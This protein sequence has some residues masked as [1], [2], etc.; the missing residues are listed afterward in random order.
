MIACPLSIA[1]PALT[2]AR[3]VPLRRLRRF[4]QAEFR[5]SIRDGMTKGVRESGSRRTVGQDMTGHR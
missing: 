4:A 5:S 3:R 1:S 2:P